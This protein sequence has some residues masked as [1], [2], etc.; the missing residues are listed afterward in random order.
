[1]KAFLQCF[2]LLGE[3]GRSAECGWAKRLQDSG[4]QVIVILDALGFSHHDSDSDSQM[5]WY[6]E[7]HPLDFNGTALRSGFLMKGEL[8][9]YEKCWQ[10]RIPKPHSGRSWKYGSTITQDVVNLAYSLLILGR[11]TFREARSLTMARF[12]SAAAWRR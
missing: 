12:F 2:L 1:M 8:Q 3:Q 7:K 4:L 11:V 9:Y 6:V 5:L 10:M